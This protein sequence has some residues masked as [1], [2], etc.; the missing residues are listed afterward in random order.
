MAQKDTIWGGIRGSTDPIKASDPL[1]KD[2]LVAVVL[3]ALSLGSI[4]AVGGIK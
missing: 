2:I 4:W 1:W 3:I